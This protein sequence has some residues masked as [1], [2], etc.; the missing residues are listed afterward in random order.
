MKNPTLH[1]R[2]GWLYRF[3]LLPYTRKNPL[4]WKDKFGFPR[5]EREPYFELEWLWFYF[6]ITWGDQDYWEQRLWIEEYHDG[7]IEQARKEWGW[8]DM[9]TEES[10]WNDKYLK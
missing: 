7:N 3:V 4:L 8:T 6:S 10:T 2:I 9:D 5:C 1:F